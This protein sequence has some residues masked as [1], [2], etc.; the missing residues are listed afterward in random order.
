M[1]LSGFIYT[2]KEL[3][4]AHGDMEIYLMDPTDGIQ[5]IDEITINKI[6][7]EKIIILS[8]SPKIGG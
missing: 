7:G 1:K 5:L 8:N 3:K 6:E 4:K 2:L